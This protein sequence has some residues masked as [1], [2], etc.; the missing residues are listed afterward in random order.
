MSAVAGEVRTDAVPAASGPDAYKWGGPGELKDMAPLAVTPGADP[1]AGEPGPSPTDA[2]QSTSPSGDGAALAAFKASVVTILREFFNSGDAQAAYNALLAL[3][4]PYFRY[5]V[6]KKAISMA[7]DGGNRER[8]LGSQLLSVLH[9]TSYLSMGAVGKGFERLF[10]TLDDLKLDVPDAEAAL[11]KFTARAVVDDI[12]PPAFLTDTHVVSTG[13]DVIARARVML[14]VK[15]A[16]IRMERVW[17]ANEANSDVAEL[18]A[19][20]Q[21]NV[22]EFFDSKDEAAIVRY[23]KAMGVPHLGH[24]LVKRVFVTAWDSRQPMADVVQLLKVLHEEGA[25][26]YAQLLAG[27][28]FVQHDLSDLALDAPTAPAQ[29]EEALGLAKDAGLPVPESA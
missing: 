15:H 24:A 23:V 16:G 14:S 5:E 22:A 10:S 29:F 28:A 1:A 11:A 12:L 25:L 2:D 7:L 3:G 26:S 17:G 20:M 18:K 13:G 27:L 8:E 6:A 21:Q 9:G 19:A 4:S